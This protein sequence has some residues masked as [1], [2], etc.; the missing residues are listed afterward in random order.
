VQRRSLSNRAF[1]SRSIRD[2]G[3]YVP[4]PSTTEEKMEILLV[5]GSPRKKGNTNILLEEALRGVE[6]VGLAGEIIQLGAMEI[7]PCIGDFHC[8]QPGHEGECVFKDD[9]QEVYEKLAECKGVIF[10]TPVWLWDMTS[11]MLLFLH[12]CIAATAKRP[13]GIKGKAAGLIVIS[14]R[15][16]NQNV[17]N[18]FNMFFNAQQM[19]SLSP[20]YG[21]A[22]HEG[23]IRND[24]HAMK[25]AYEMGR[26]M[27]LVAKENR[28]IEMPEEYQFKNM[29]L[30][31]CEKY[32]IPLAP[33]GTF[34]PTYS[35]RN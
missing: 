23:E 30:Y 12:R 34:T 10:G 18:V 19:L 7:T 26:C 35:K 33:G 9:M 4:Q 6:D 24:V 28:R 1:A 17:A 2:F 31:V 16:G 25:S 5:N 11:Q 13:L 21:Y 8:L 27:G 20:V 3:V 22:E 14:G 32:G 29:P 15:R